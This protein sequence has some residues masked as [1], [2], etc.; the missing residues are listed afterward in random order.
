[1]HQVRVVACP[2]YANFHACPLCALYPTQGFRGLLIV[3]LGA[4]RCNAAW[5]CSQRCLKADSSKHGSSG[6]CNLLQDPASM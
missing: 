3:F 5:Y 4:H 1:M 2:E 6:E